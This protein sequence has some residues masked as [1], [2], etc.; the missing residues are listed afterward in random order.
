MNGMRL[1][2]VLGTVLVALAGLGAPGANADDD[3]GDDWQALQVEIAGQ[4]SVSGSGGFAC[5]N[6]HSADHCSKAYAFGSVV[7]LVAAPAPGWLFGGWQGCE[8][9]TGTICQVFLDEAGGG[10]T[11]V[12][13]RF[14]PFDP[15]PSQQP[16]TVAVDGPGHVSG[17]G[18][19]C[20]GDCEQSFIG[21][22]AITLHAQAA[23]LAAFTGWSGACTGGPTSAC[24]VSMHGPRNVVAHFAP[25]IPVGQPRTLAVQVAGT[26]AGK[27]TSGSA[28]DCP[29]D[30]SQTYS[31]TADV[32]LTASPAA[33]ST[34]A[35]WTGDC[36]G[37]SAVCTVTMASS[38]SVTATF[39]RSQPGPTPPGGPGG[40]GGPGAPGD[41]SRPGTPAPSAPS[42]PVPNKP[43][44]CTITGTPGNDVLVGTPGRDVICG[45]GGSDRLVGKGGADLLIGGNGPDQLLGGPGADLLVG[46]AGRDRLVGGA[47]ADR[48]EAGAG[49]DRLTGGRGADRLVGG[50]GLD[51]LLARDGQRD[52]VDGGK[53]RDR[54]RLDR[55]KDAM[56]RIETLV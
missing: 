53:G 38:R 33:G 4:G 8:Q 37:A 30:C 6:A 40:P 46:G 52:R 56:T 43:V 28:I 32:T 18:I 50:K 45:L 55:A 22:A 12:S 23:P 16:L 27:V 3:L 24:V 10:N 5:P 19:A 47:G 42:S 39:E 15:T 29:G 36:S 41:P 1:L 25:D 14:V 26:G 34:F 31:V 13:V 7:N 11:W 17:T 44:A 21:G 48:L 20:P 49:N 51:L 35:G 9:S 54:A 2:L